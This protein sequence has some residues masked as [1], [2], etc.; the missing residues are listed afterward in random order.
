MTVIK[1]KCENAPLSR[2]NFFLLQ[3]KVG[4]R[5]LSQINEFGPKEMSLGVFPS[6]FNQCLT[7]VWDI[8]YGDRERDSV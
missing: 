4:L 5:L 1:G 7:K 6:F 8:L 3:N 2:G